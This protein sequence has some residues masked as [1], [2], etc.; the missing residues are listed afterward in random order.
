MR[1]DSSLRGGADAFRALALGARAVLI[2][3]EAELDLTMAL[4]GCSTLA[5]VAG[6]ALV[7]P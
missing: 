4:T 6:A 5:D 2:D 3:F 1:L 7:P